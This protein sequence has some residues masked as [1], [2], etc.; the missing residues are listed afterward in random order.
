M[1]SQQSDELSHLAGAFGMDRTNNGSAPRPSKR[2]HAGGRAPQQPQ[3]HSVPHHQ[4]APLF[5]EPSPFSMQSTQQSVWPP[6][7]S[8]TPTSHTPSQSPVGSNQH[9]NQGNQSMEAFK[10]MVLQMASFFHQH[11][12]ANMPP[13]FE[14][15][16]SQMSV[17]SPNQ[18]ATTAS[19]FPSQ[20]QQ[21]QSYVQD[22]AIVDMGGFMAS[23]GAPKPQ[24][25]A[26]AEAPIAPAFQQQ[27]QQRPTQGHQLDH[28]A[29]PYTGSHSRGPRPNSN[30]NSNNT[31]RQQN[32]NGPR[33]HGRQAFQAPP[34]EQSEPKIVVLVEFKRQRMKK[35]ESHMFVAPGQ[36]VVVE[37]DRGLDCGFVIHCCVREVDG[38]YSKQESIDNVQVDVS[39]IKSESGKVLR[40][41]RDDDV[42]LLHGEIA[43]SELMALKTCRDMAARMNLTMEIVDCEYQ[44]DRKKISFYFEAPHS[45]DFRELNTELFRVF[46]VRIWLENLNSKV[47]N[48]V[49]EGA[50]SH[51][52]KLQYTKNGLRPPRRAM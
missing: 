15:L 41:A 19:P 10:S 51:A 14:G 12:E 42:K 36:Y 22:D 20:F 28:Q 24:R 40:L 9:N 32:T 46:G 26:Y 23:Q 5:H 31:Y 43:S 52:D 17:S 25:R 8:H 47:K 44:F 39:R 4:S 30:S 34:M 48:V 50:L 29:A 3:Q 35:Y 49:P 2:A 33:A 45:V 6:A 1:A 21:P 7:A 11:P 37:G 18:T 16:F 38:T 13:G 27:Q